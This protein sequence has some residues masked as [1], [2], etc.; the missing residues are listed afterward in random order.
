ML[1]K[2]K[3]ISMHKNLI[4]PDNNIPIHVLLGGPTK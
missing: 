2:K 1:K 4:E 3:N